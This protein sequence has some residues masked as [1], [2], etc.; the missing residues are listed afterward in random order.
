MKRMFFIMGMA[1]LAGGLLF[2]RGKKDAPERD[3]A[4]GEGTG[5]IVRIT[6][7]VTIFGNEPHT[8]AGIVTVDGKRYGVSPAEKETAIRGLQGHVV[9]FTVQFLETQEGYAALFL[10]DG[11][12]TPLSWRIV[13][14]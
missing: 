13:D 6:G 9:E 12:V 5:R 11:A 4:Y 1:A 2:A 14:G 3:G 10:K 7:R 8:F